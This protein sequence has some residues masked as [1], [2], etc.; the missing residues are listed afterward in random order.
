VLRS[1]AGKKSVERIVGSCS[2]S[3]TTVETAVATTA[4]PYDSARDAARPDGRFNVSI[5]TLAVY[6]ATHRAGKIA[7]AEGQSRRMAAFGHP[8]LEG[9]P[10]TGPAHDHPWPRCGYCGL[11]PHPVKRR[12][13][14]HV[15][16]DATARR[17]S[18]PYLREF[19]ACAA[20]VHR[21]P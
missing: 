21:F 2:S 7:D 18:S 14:G 5:R 1:I 16:R 10:T 6:R 11:E 8:N 19:G 9:R 4:T 12:I 13:N 15:S 17:L 3:V 20:P